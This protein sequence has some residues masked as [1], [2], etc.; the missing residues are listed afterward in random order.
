MNPWRVQVDCFDCG[1]VVV[2]PAEFEVVINDTDVESGFVFVCPVCGSDVVQ[3]APVS[4]LEVL[5]TAGACVHDTRDT[6]E[7][8][9]LASPLTQAHVEDLIWRIKSV[10]FIASHAAREQRDRPL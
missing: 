6:G 8:Q 9:P 3:H 5:A 10:E 4:V 7:A 1:V 2:S